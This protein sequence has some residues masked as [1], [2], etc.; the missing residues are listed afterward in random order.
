MLFSATSLRPRRRIHLPYSPPPTRLHPSGRVLCTVLLGY[1]STLTRSLF[2]PWAR[3]SERLT[4]PSRPTS[5]FRLA[6]R[7]VRAAPSTRRTRSTLPDPSNPP[8][9]LRCGARQ[10]HPVAAAASAPTTAA[11]LS[12]AGLSHEIRQPHRAEPYARNATTVP[13]FHGAEPFASCVEGPPPMGCPLTHHL[14][15]LRCSLP[16]VH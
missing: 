12:A 5:T 3:L 16:L 4:F 9:C 6:D 8:P 14:R 10:D 7:R 13:S 1:Q 11:D 15:C 2:S